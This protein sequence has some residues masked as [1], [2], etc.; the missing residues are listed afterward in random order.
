TVF[1]IDEP[2]AHMSP[3]LQSA[4]LDELL[5]AVPETS[6]LW[7]ATHSVGMMRKARDLA[8]RTPGSV[9]FLDFEG[10]NFDLPQTLRPIEPNRPF[11]KRAMQIAL[12]DL[13]G[14]VTPE[15]VVLCEGG[16][17]E[18][19]KDFDAACYNEIFQ[20]EYPQV[21]FLGAGNADDIQ[22]DPRGVGR[23]LRALAPEVHVTRVI[24]RDD[25]TDEEI[26]TLRSQ[27]V[28]VLSLRT[29][30]SY[31]LDDSVMKIMCESFGQPELA[32]QLLDAKAEAL[33]N[34]IANGGPVDDLKRPAG[35]IYNA[36][37]RL[38]P[39]HKFGS[40]KRTFMKGICAPLIRPGVPIYVVL[41]KDVFGE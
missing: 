40:D 3:G 31:L 1:F 6:Q 27:Q 24:D 33:R 5:C 32:P 17:L 18:G 34:S 7:L 13:A 38:F 35:D 10:V 39:T 2:E 25:R 21:V 29:I 4:L 11:W 15:Q 30:E 36:A 41:Q 8:Q 26:R 19:G 22:N 23:L 9:V 16:R 12:D 20:T 37:K 14:Y 28:H